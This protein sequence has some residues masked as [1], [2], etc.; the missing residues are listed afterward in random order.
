LDFLVQ[1]DVNLPPELPAA[2]RSAVLGA[3]KAR[4]LELKA[5]GTIQR[6]W[7]IP[8]RLANVGVW[9]AD[10][11]TRLHAVLES[12]PVFRYADI[13]VTPLATHYLEL[14]SRADCGSDS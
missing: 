2:D 14:S 9:S 5:A 6:I 13:R 3:E 10:D 12:L 1:I 4:G 8:G 11:A 7:R